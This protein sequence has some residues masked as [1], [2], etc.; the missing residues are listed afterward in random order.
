MSD[1]STRDR[2]QWWQEARFGMFIH[3]G[4][5]A[6]PGRGEWVYYQEHWDTA[7]YAK[8]ADEFN[9]RY[10]DAREWVRLAQ[11]AGMK[12]MVLTTRHHDGFC[13]F[14]SAVSEF[15]APR[16]GAKRDLIAEYAE[17]CH[18]LGMPMGFYYSLEDW[19]FPEQLPHLPI[20]DDLSV[21]E[22]M[23]EQAHAQVRELMSNYGTVD[24]LWYD[25]GFPGGVWRADELNAMARRLQPGIIINN[26][27]GPDEDFG[28]PENQIQ[29][30]DRPWEACYTM[31]DSWGFA[32]W[33]RNYKSPTEILHLLSTCVAGGGNLLLNVGPDPE[34]RIPQAAV[35]RL[36]HVGA[37]MRTNGESVYGT[38][39][40]PVPTPAVGWATSNGSAVYVHVWRWP[41]S[42]LRLA[43]I[44]SRVKSA[45][46]LGLDVRVEV[47]QAGDRVVLRGLPSSPPNPFMGVI[48]L[49]F[50]GEPHMSEPAYS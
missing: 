45:R 34:G 4:V 20:R 25:G 27:S 24:I 40:S 48:A 38:T 44:G 35:D 13:L 17:A 26:R 5:Y 21:Y 18:N 15:T 39:S 33:D 1:S 29:F 50:D 42:E 32:E 14:D 22:P 28:T 46:V 2:M 19:R 47:D 12:Y 16:T 10:Y 36:R 9:P 43:W 31:N 23:V 49:E 41:G 11:D 37:W 30:L 8:L 7:E 3:W 6:I